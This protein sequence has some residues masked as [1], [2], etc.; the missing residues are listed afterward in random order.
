MTPENFVRAETDMEFSRSVES[1]GFGRF[2][3]NRELM[4]IDGQTVVRPNRDTLYSS[5]VFDLDAGPVTVTLPDSG[6]RYMAMQVLDED[7]YTHQVV[8]KSGSYTFDR[9]EIGTRYLMLA[10]RTFVDPN[11]PA[12]LDTVHR[13][14][15]AIKVGQPTGPG[16]FEIPQWDPVSQ[17]VVRDALLTLAGTLPNTNGAFGPRDEVDPIQHLIGA[18]SAWGGNP[19]RDAVYLTV[20][21]AGNDGATDYTLHVKDVPVKGF[22]SISLYNAEG[23]FQANPLNAYS[24]N[25]VTAATNPDGSVDIRFGGCDARPGNCLPIMPGW[26]Y[27]VR[28][29]EPEPSIL[30]GQWTFPQ[31]TPVR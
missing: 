4:P 5:A 23:Y 10:V 2:H 9:D 17:K 28:L 30:N 13:L 11:S 16:T 15:D 22:W 20:T 6:T 3:H 8:Y 31:P 19:L 12:D 26:N 25:N 21:P 7:E 1:G 14:Q 24:I 27:M 18:A 29:Y